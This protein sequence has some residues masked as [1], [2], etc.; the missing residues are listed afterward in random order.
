[1]K[2]KFYLLFATIALHLSSQSQCVITSNISSLQ[3]NTFCEPA[4]VNLQA[5]NLNSS[6]MWTQKND[7]D[8]GVRESG[9]SFSIAGKG[10][11]GLGSDGIN[12]LVDLWEYDPITDTWSQKAN[13]PGTFRNGASC[14][15]INNKAY[16]GLGVTAGPTF[17]SDLWEYDPASDTWTQKTSLPISA[18]PRAYATGFSIENYG[19]FGLG[20]TSYTGGSPFT[21]DFWRYNPTTDTWTQVSNFPASARENAI[22][23][24]IG[25]LAYIGQGNVNGGPFEKDLWEYNPITDIW[26]QKANYANS[27]GRTRT[28]AF[29]LN[30]KGYVV[31]GDAS[32]TG[33]LILMKEYN[34]LNN[35]WIVKENFPGITRIGASGFVIDNKAYIVGGRDYNT[36]NININEVQEYNGTLIYLWSTG[37]NTKNIIVNSTGQY[38]VN[39]T[40]PNGCSA[41]ANITINVNPLPDIGLTVNNT[42]LTVNEIGATYQWYQCV[43]SPPPAGLIMIPGETNQSFTAT[44]NGDYAAIVTTSNGCVD[45]T[46]CSSITT[47]GINELDNKNNSI[48]FPNPSNGK[49]N[50]QTTEKGIYFIMDALGNIIKTLDIQENKSNTEILISTNGVYFIVG[51]NSRQKIIIGK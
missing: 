39:I 30:D 36:S 44:S 28:V 32:S 38:S 41:S 40:D 1:M 19:Y 35:T 10:Y 6:G 12:T 3:G 5:T 48:A 37:E 4:N 51:P 29:S 45:T 42:T 8:N 49:F 2:S 25:G 50:L 18:L 43:T 26:S 24:T 23:F 47:V 31:T 46:E 20:R 17:L 14:F 11:F 33:G 15:T 9:V 27:S 34:P 22:S 16:I 13:F 7:F 21:N